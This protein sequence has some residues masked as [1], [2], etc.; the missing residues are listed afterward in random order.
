MLYLNICMIIYLHKYNKL[1]NNSKLIGKI[2][3]FLWV[4]KIY[5]ERYQTILPINELG[6]QILVAMKWP[7]AIETLC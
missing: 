5:R 1:M 2:K 3:V 4:K 7:K 6:V